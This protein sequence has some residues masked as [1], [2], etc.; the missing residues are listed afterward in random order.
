ELEH[1]TALAE[2]GQRLALRQVINAAAQFLNEIPTTPPTVRTG[3]R[4][5][6]TRLEDEDA[7]P[8]GGV[9]SLSNRGS[10]ESLLHSQ[11]AYMEDDRP[12]PF[13]VKI[14]R[15][16]LLYY[17]RDENQF[18]RRRRRFRFQFAADLATSR[19]KDPDLPFQ[20]IVLT[21]AAVAAIVERLTEWLA[22]D[23]LMFEL[24]WPAQ[25]AAERDLLTTIFREQIATGLVRN[26][27][28]DLPATTLL[29]STH[30]SDEVESL[31]VDHRPRLSNDLDDETES[32]WE[33]W[34]KCIG[35]LLAQWM[36]Q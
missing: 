15:D 34:T 9:A 16:E 33:S 24:V 26:H 32:A 30:P 14:L 6:P 35:A 13:D 22:E 36:D 4:E 23:S 25:L 12:D 21:M 7:Y 29:I 20:R 17:S 28:E 8:V 18:Y 3:R 1:R 2:F 5:A 10:M 31:V 27:T 19:F 11:L